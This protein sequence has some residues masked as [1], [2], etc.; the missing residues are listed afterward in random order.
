MSQAEDP[1]PLR[2]CELVDNTCCCK[3]PKVA[4]AVIEAEHQD[5]TAYVVSH[6]REPFFVA[7]S[8]GVFG[9]D[10]RDGYFP[11]L[12]SHSDNIGSQV[13]SVRG[14]P[15]HPTE[16]WCTAVSPS[17]VMRDPEFSVSRFQIGTMRVFA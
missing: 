17:L 6:Q 3:W 16:P 10:L 12:L 5:I 13:L 2:K 14:L 15:L 4:D 9:G 7:A 8:P 11:W 1:N